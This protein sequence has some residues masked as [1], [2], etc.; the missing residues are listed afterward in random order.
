[1][2]AAIACV[3]IV[4]I[5]L[6]VAL[7]LIFLRGGDADTVSTTVAST[8]TSV[9]TPPTSASTTET[10]E[11]ATTT[12][13][14]ATTTTAKADSS[15]PGDSAGAWSAVDVAG[16]SLNVNEVAVS[17]D[18]LLF[19]TAADTGPGSI[20]AYIFASGKTVQ[21]PT[22]GTTI[23][24]MDVDGALAVWWEAEGADVTANAHIYA[25]HLPDGP[26][27]EVASGAG[28]TYPHVKGRLITW[29]DGKPLASDPTNWYDYVIKAAAVDAQG[30]PTGA[31]TTLV[32]AGSAIASS[33]GD[34]SWYYSLSDGF[35][36]WEQQYGSGAIGPGTYMMDLGEMQPW[37]VDPDAWRPSLYKNRVVFTRNGVETAQ[38]GSKNAV[39]LDA[40]ADFATAAPTYAAFFRPK[41]A[42]SGTAWA[43]VA[44]GYNGKYEQVL[45][46]DAGSPPWLLSPIAASA[47]RIAFAFGGKLQLF[48]WQ[49]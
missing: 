9:T 33:T 10:T 48:S 25:Y 31:P 43:V 29:A 42:G 40:S 27:V 11:G 37:R 32:D 14:A 22:G 16:L 45:L 24:Y 3:G 7:P 47:H 18:A 8:S 17:D 4:V 20:Y 34:T 35:I 30:Q 36:A 15:I 2:W 46:D 1:M 23:G 12:T 13:E 19:R 28:V 6:A 44:R 39:T 5:A 38:F 41:V 26:K 21:L 49:E